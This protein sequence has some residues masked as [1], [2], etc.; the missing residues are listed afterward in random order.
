[1][2]KK[3]FF[4]LL[5]LVIANGLF[6]ND[7]S[8]QGRSAYE[9]YGKLQEAA[10]TFNQNTLLVNGAA[11]DG[12]TAGVT[13]GAEKEASSGLITR[14]M[15]PP[16][17]HFKSVVGNLS[18]AREKAFLKDFF[19]RY[20]S[21]R[22]GYSSRIYR[23][24]EGKTVDLARD[25][26]DLEGDPKLIKIDELRI[27]DIGGASLDTLKQKW[28]AWLKMSEDRPFSFLA[29]KYR[30]ELFKGEVNGLVSSPFKNY[31][32]FK[33]KP[34]F[35]LAEKYIESVH[36]QATNEG[37]EIIFRPQDTYGEFEAGIA[38]F[39]NELKNADNLFQRPGHQRIVF[40]QHPD[41][42]KKKLA[43]LYKV[44]Q[45]LIYVE[46]VQGKT[47]IQKA[48]YKN[49]TVDREI[50]ELN[51][52]KGVIRLEGDRFG[53]N[54]M[55]VEFRAG[56]KDT[57]VARFIQT[58]F[59]SRVAANDF[60]GMAN[61]SSWKLFK[62]TNL[63]THNRLK[64][65]F[66][67]TNTQIAKII[68]ILEKAGLFEHRIENSLKLIP[69]WGWTTPNS[70][71][72]ASS[73]RDLLNKGPTRDFLLKVGDLDMEFGS[74]ELFHE[75]H[76]LMRNWIK[77][78]GVIEDLKN[79]IRPKP[80]APLSQDLFT[81][82][83][84]RAPPGRAAVDV[85][86][87][88]LGIEY[89]GT[90]PLQ[91]DANYSSR[92]RL[93][94][95]QRAW[96]STN[97]DL[98]FSQR[99]EIIENVASD[100]ARELGAENN[101]PVRLNTLSHGHTLE[102]SYEINDPEGRKWIVEW[103]G[104]NRSYTPQG[105][106][107]EDSIRGGVVE[108]VTPKFNPK[109]GEIEKIYSVFKENNIL[110]RKESGGGHINIDLAAFSRKPRELARFISLFHE[111]RGIIAMMFQY[112]DRIKVA[113]PLE[114][115]ETLSQKLK[116]FSGSETDLKK[117]L[118]NERY[119]NTRAGRKTRYIQ[120]VLDAYFQDVI[121]SKFITNDFDIKNPAVPWR[122]E[123]NVDPKIRKMEFRLFNAPRNVHE[124][125]LQIRLVRALLNKALNDE[126][127]LS[128]NVQNTSH[129]DYLKN[130]NLAERDLKKLC[131]ELELNIE[132][133]QSPVAAESLSDIQLAKQSEF[134]TSPKE[135][136][137]NFPKQETGWHQALNNERSLRAALASRERP[138][139]HERQRHLQTMTLDDGG[140]QV[141]DTIKLGDLPTNG[142]QSSCI[143]AL[144][145]LFPR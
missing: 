4:T 135:K 69:L 37:W 98:T 17:S 134:F 1:M 88:D 109:V 34:I 122:R 45:A 142:S 57:R 16:E 42:D 65:E 74:D 63:I 80:I 54:T 117:L 81:V 75:I 50:A 35:G 32:S 18:S 26:K 12:R 64:R 97:H 15:T 71:F 14:V 61:A 7:P 121:P 115:S 13:W 132:D 116:N 82:N 86:K 73:K 2:L 93:L 104:I 76:A 70:P 140:I 125:A 66:G 3:S 144:S 131:A 10:V 84:A 83:S 96:V 59:A 39:R 101:R 20:K 9:I 95:G 145:N 30:M 6:G 47:G 79:Y 53:D 124:S 105:D 89:T 127:P 25:V 51:T 100:L 133:F 85:N 56:T 94:N 114:I 128:G 139:S 92:E 137:K 136:L 67:L 141:G 22:V 28:R 102:I 55:A 110:P 68:S 41:L 8:S 36:Q 90:F 19:K 91:L 24:R 40:Y 43:E 130:P 62:E 38:W 126:G 106:I 99:E 103:D 48:N 107:V 87:I 31:D 78:S 113:E 49:L 111:H 33:W 120:L 23:T 11:Q 52:L 123:F 60:S 44:I 108:L 27:D 129:L 143:N 138:W 29:P 58:S 112:I 21:N 72:I 118:Y 5:L 119:F 46:G 77:S